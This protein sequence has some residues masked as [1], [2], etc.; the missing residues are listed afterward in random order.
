[1]HVLPYTC[2]AICMR[3]YMHVLPYAC[4]AIYMCCHMHVLPELRTRSYT[5]VA[6]GMCTCHMHMLPY[7]CVAI[8]MCC[9]MHALLYAC[10]AMVGQLIILFDYINNVVKK[11]I[12]I[13]RG[14][15]RISQ[16]GG[17]P[18]KKNFGSWIYMPQSGMSRAAKLRA[19]A[20]G[21]WGHAPP[22]KFLEMVQFRAF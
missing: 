3:C 2:V 22:R 6:I 4:V 8:C 11:S 16:G 7:A 5:C 9:H 15:C 19:V 13:Y 17:G 1:M 20:R 10:D 18:T 14:V 21:V 12:I